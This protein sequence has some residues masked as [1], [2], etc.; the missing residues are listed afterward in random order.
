MV[1]LRYVYILLSGGEYFS[2]STADPMYV[3]ESFRKKEPNSKFTVVCA[4]GESEAKRAS[5][6]LK[7]MKPVDYAYWAK[8]SRAQQAQWI[9]KTANIH[10][11]MG[12][13]C[14]DKFN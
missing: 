12:V 6:W 1:R 14:S 3:L 13:D 8:Q 11:V 2:G 4:M 10:V 5:R 7:R 9:C